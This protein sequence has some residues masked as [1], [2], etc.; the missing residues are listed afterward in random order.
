MK[1]LRRL[2]VPL[3]F[4][5]QNLLNTPRIYTYSMQP[6][7]FVTNCFEYFIEMYVYQLQPLQ[8]KNKEDIYS[9]VSWLQLYN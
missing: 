2:K 5:P 8:T 6:E 1:G 9:N 3:N 7:L 4:F